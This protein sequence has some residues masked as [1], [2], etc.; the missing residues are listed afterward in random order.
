MLPRTH[1]PPPPLPP[2]AQQT[3]TQVAG[4]LRQ[5]D[6]ALENKQYDVAIKLYEDAL[7]LD[8]QNARADQGR[9]GAITAR[10]VAEAA[11]SGG[12]GAKTGKSFVASRTQAS[13]GEEKGG[14]VPPGFEDSAGVVA[15]KGTQAAELPGKIN[16]DFNPDTVKPG[17]RFT[18]NISLLNEG[19]API[20]IQS[21]VV[22]TTINGKRAGGGPVSPLAKEVAPKQ[23]TVVL[24]VSDI[25][26]E[27]TNSW[28]MEVTVRTILGET[29]KNSVKWQ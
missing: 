15:K 27:D 17:E 8:P 4:F 3:A 6:D 28:T 12:G 25:W 13:S 21:L 24:S 9:S 26:K 14:N 5:A 18:A 20:Q 1:P 16:F 19:L 22:T 7:R 23:K 2:A 11:A 29:Y 10:S